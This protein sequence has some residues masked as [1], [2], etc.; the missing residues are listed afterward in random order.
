MSSWVSGWAMTHW[1]K[2]NFF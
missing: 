2:C 1:R